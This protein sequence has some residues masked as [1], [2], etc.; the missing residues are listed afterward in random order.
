MPVTALVSMLTAL[1][2]SGASTAV[3]IIFSSETYAIIIL[4][5][6][7][8]QLRKE[9]GNPQLRSKLD[10]GISGTE[11]LKRAIVRPTK[12]VLFSPINTLLAALCAII[13]GAMYLLLTTLPMVFETVYGFS[14]AASGLAYI[15]QGVGSTI[16]LLIF[17]LTSDRYIAQRAAKGVLKP[18]DRLP[19][20][21]LSGPIIAI[22]YIWYGWS[23]R[24]QIYWMM[25]IVG[26]GILGMGNVF[27]FLPVVGYLVDAFTIYAASAIAS[28]TVFR[29]IG[30]ALLPLAGPRMYEKLGFGW[31]NTLLAFL[32]LMFSP[33]LIIIYRH[34]E[35]IR[36]KWPLNL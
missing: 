34:G 36:T 7:T 18:E 14:T 1:V 31:G 23:S 26:S 30:G 32:I 5:R 33:M 20:L 27:F 29:S 11:I 8:K 12:I 15:G 2:Q 13:Y 22:G 10:R 16:G 25:P 19:L 9:T 35:Y 17:S 24:L 28:N 6:K 4:D 3:Q 21:I